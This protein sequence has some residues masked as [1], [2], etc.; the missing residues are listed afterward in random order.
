MSRVTTPSSAA[1]RDGRRP[2]RL[3]WS[4]LLPLAGIAVLLAAL[5][6]LVSVQLPG[7]P[8]LVPLLLVVVACFDLFSVV[9]LTSIFRTTGE[10][11]TLL[12][13]GSYVFALLTAVYRGLAYPGEA[14]MQGAW[15]GAAAVTPWLWAVW[16]GGFAVLVALSMAPWP[17]RLRATV[18]PGRRTPLAIAVHGIAGLLATAGAGLLL[19]V[20]DRLP[21]LIVGND[22]SGL[23]R[24]TGP[25]LLPLLVVCS[26]VTIAGS[27]GR[28]GPL[29]WTGLAAA[30]ALGEVVVSLAGP[31]RYSGAWYTARVLS[32]L[33]ACVLVAALV[34]EYAAIRRRLT[35]EGE[36]LREAL[37]RTR[38]L[39][40]V[41]STL[42]Q[43]LGDGVLMWDRDDRIVASNPA[44]HELLGMDSHQ[45]TVG[46]K[47]PWRAFR[48]D[49][50][51]WEAVDLPTRT[52]FR[53][54]EGQRG[55]VVGMAGPAGVRWLSVTTEPVRGAGGAVEYVVTSM[56][57]V[58]EEHAA[59]LAAE[60][61]HRI[62]RA[63]I[64]QLL[65]A[66]GPDVVLQPIVELATG[67]VVGH[68]ALAR[69]PGRPQRTPDAWFADA[70]AV[71]LGV[72]LE[73]SAVAAALG[74]FRRLPPG[75]HLSIN[76]GPD[77][78]L[79]AQ[80]P[81]LFRGLPEDRPVILELTEHVGVDD[82]AALTAALERVRRLGVRLA[83][84]D[85]GSGFAS[86]R[87]I[88][89]L[90]P[91]VIKLDRDLVTG[92]DGDPARRALAGALLTFGTEIG[93]EV[94]AEGIETAAEAAA[95]QRLGIRLGQGFHLG[96]PGPCP[97]LTSTIGSR[98]AAGADGGTTGALGGTGVSRT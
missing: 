44:A 47:P 20:V 6:L 17:R 62:R 78:A 27:W 93:A 54:G 22:T 19:A 58:T 15:T 25:W 34:G 32:V 21:T 55:Q 53:T 97:Q 75:T 42:L 92:V 52:A 72:E 59:A 14:G 11:R 13:A 96:R 35:R 48:L 94:V 60:D 87:H 49:G 8:G 95:L 28:T 88:L 57:D 71:G 30:A 41:Q 31:A 29:R 2:V 38:E 36:L 73:L 76:V 40:Q 50:T 63:R 79:S 83:V 24:T 89:N 90:R 56:R 86:L 43:H 82:Y 46:P 37:A 33:A 51:P 10:P 98:S 84:D 39:E 64:E 68:E 45:L 23:T 77:T 74:A 26:A 3:P 69:F 81:E 9:L 18:P 12:L 4:S 67:R 7:R 61:E 70:A 16:H 5:P 91:D 80:L 85:A 65:V 66:G 1:V